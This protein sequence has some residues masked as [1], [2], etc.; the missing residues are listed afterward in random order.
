MGATADG[1]KELLAVMDGCRES[2]QSWYELLVDLKQRGLTQAPQS[3]I[4][5]GALGSWGALRKM[6][7]RTRE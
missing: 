2:E 1:Y 7:P 6:H 3:A 5:D 4:E